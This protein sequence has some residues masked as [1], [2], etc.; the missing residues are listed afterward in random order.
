MDYEDLTAAGG[1]FLPPAGRRYGTNVSVVG[2]YGNYWS[3]SSGIQYIA[4]A[5]DFSGDIYSYVTPSMSYERDRGF[6]VRL[7]RDLL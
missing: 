6:S 5:L 7:V 2:L 1:V 4:S 3:S